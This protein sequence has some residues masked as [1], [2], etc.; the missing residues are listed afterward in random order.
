[1][2]RSAS[3]PCGAVRQVFLTRQ[4]ISLEPLLKVV[5][6]IPLADRTLLVG[7]A[8]ACRHADGT[9]SSPCVQ[10]VRRMASED[11]DQLCPGLTAIHRLGDL[12]DLDQ[13]LRA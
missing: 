8:P 13:P 7:A 2:S 6:Y 5:D 11:S 12:R 1:M 3:A 4:G 10:G 9:I